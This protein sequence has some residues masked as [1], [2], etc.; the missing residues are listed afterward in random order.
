MKRNYPPGKRYYANHF[1]F[2]EVREYRTDRLICEVPGL[3]THTPKDQDRIATM[4]A[5]AINRLE[6]RDQP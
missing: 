1:V 4:I 2:G 3:P 5:R 6:R